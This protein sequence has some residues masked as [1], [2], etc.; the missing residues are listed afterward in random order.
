M[1]VNFTPV[2]SLIG[3][4]LI[5][6]SASLLLA[7]HGR[8]AGISGIWGGL[9]RPKRSDIGWR[10]TFV[11][12]L[13]AG[14]ALIA[15][16]LP[17]AVG[18]SRRSV[19]RRGGRGGAAGGGRHPHRQRL[20][21]RPR[22]V[23]GCPACRCDRRWPWS[24]SWPP[25]SSSPASSALWGCCDVAPG[26]VRGGVVVRD[27]PGDRGHDRR[28]QGHRVSSTSPGAGIRPSPWSWWGPSRSTPWPTA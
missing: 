17:A 25:A 14:A 16:G 7:T 4:A 22:R 27:W 23:R 15:W 26:V 8:I 20:H 21:Q 10:A 13:A 6:L 5:G 3:G 12:G 2:S 19:P 28:Q 11:A 9:L 18:G 24:P 1:I